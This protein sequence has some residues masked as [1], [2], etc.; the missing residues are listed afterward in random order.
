[1]N[2]GGTFTWIESKIIDVD[3]LWNIEGC[4]RFLSDGIR[5]DKYDGKYEIFPAK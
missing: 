5:L 2:R 4:P 1:M 3:I